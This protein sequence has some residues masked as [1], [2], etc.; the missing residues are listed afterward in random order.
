M[1]KI[2]V[3]E[4]LKDCPTGMELD[5]P[6]WDNIEFDKIDGDNIVIFRKYGGFRVHLS[7]Y[8]AMSDN[9]G[10]CIIFPKGKT[11]WE[12]FVTPCKF[13]DGD[14]LAAE[15]VWGTHIFI[16][17]QEYIENTNILQTEILNT[18]FKLRVTQTDFVPISENVLIN[19]K[20]YDNTY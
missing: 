12:G 19:N 14:I 10:K 16:Y 9:D 17:N 7:R 6:V 18:Y 2:N 1:E 4:L 15:S 13:K 3:A 8:G 11:T 5:S 20:Y